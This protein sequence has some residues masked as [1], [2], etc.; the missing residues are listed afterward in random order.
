MIK[1]YDEHTDGV[2]TV[3]YLREG[4]FDCVMMTGGTRP[5]IFPK[6]DGVYINPDCTMGMVNH[7]YSLNA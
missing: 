1:L 4:D 6:V 2:V 7:S 5:H 3:G